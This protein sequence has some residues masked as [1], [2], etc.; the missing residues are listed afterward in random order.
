[1]TGKITPG[2]T[3]A[4][5]VGLL[6]FGF[7]G[8]SFAQTLA[9]GADVQVSLW[10]ILAALFFCIGLAVAGAFALKLRLNN[11]GGGRTAALGIISG[12]LKFKLPSLR[13]QSR[14]RLIE[15]LHVS[16]QLEICLFAFDQQQF[17]IA[18][19]PQGVVVLDRGAAADAD[20]SVQ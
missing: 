1:M 14:L 18:A 5:P 19:C 6:A 9:Q 10:R 4:L 2:P 7:A 17:L 3:V 8:P 15:T 16:A 12:A 13:G 11:G 20:P